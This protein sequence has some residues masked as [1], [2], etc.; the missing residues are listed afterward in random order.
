MVITEDL[1]KGAKNLLINCARLSSLDRLLVILESPILGWYEEEI[2]T[3]VISEAEDMGI[4]TEKIIVGEPK[5]KSDSI[6]EELIN[7]HDC[8][9]FFAR[10]GD[11][12]RFEKKTIK[13][14]R[15]MSYARN[16][17]NLASSFGRTNY[18]ATLEMK[19]EIN[20]LFYKSKK[21]EVECP[22]GTKLIGKLSSDKPIKQ[23][24]VTVTRFPIVVPMPISASG[25][26][27]KVVI[28]KY[29]TST[30]SKVYDPAS[31]NIRESITAKISDG[32]IDK[33]EGTPKEIR[34][35]DDHYEK[36]AKLFNLDK[37]IVHSW[38]AGIHSGITY[39]SMAEDNPDRW[40]NTIFPSPD[41][42]HFHTCGNYAPGEICW[43]IK[44]PI[45][46]IDGISLWENA[47]VKVENFETTSK[48]L[49]KWP[50]LEQIYC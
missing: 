29:I 42:L 20:N 9:I 14:K 48:I 34:N 33:F 21:I 38:H 6:L 25:F 43:M 46:K 28:S 4:R 12:D 35:I 39:D 47:K 7:K 5:N 3:I 24:D 11:Q 18:Q 26:S 49:E 2:A 23:C 15:I 13:K 19:N 45:I 40:A 37:N 1:K 16:L 17:D 22:L 36:I 10:V 32:R 30:G 8:T 27:G 50:D 44:S 41:Y 31:L